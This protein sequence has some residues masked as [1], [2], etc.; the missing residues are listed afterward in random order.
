MSSENAFLRAPETP[1]AVAFNQIG[2]AVR[3]MLGRPAGA[4]AQARREPAQAPDAS[5][6][7]A[8]QPPAT[9]VDRFDAARKRADALQTAYLA[10]WRMRSL[11]EVPA[12]CTRVMSETTGLLLESMT[13]TAA[14]SADVIKTTSHAFFKDRLGFMSWPL[15]RR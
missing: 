4:L 11:D 15:S 13:A 2:A 5:D 3:E 14:F 9:P 12:V 6:V 1:D 8:A 10:L 7:P